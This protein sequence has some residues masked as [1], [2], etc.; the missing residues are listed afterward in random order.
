MVTHDDL[1]A[2]PFSALTPLAPAW[3]V[4]IGVANDD[5]DRRAVW[6]VTHCVREQVVESAL[7]V[8]GNNVGGRVICHFNKDGEIARARNAA[9]AFRAAFHEGS[10]RL[11]F[12]GRRGSLLVMAG[13]EEKLFG[14][15]CQSSCIL[16]GIGDGLAKC[17]DRVAVALSEFQL[18]LQE[19]DRS[20]Q[21]V[22]G[23]GDE[24]ALL[25]KCATQ[26]AE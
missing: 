26:G 24:G 19:R 16:S 1:D 23:V 22:P 18:G 5:L 3:L 6:C 17:V 9:R 14:E 20:S 8:V 12:T 11:E 4:R 21:F 25:R 7:D 2:P 13:K 15:G 10:Q